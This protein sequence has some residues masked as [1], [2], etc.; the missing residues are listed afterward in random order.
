MPKPNQLFAN[1]VLADTFERIVREAEALGVDREPQLEAA[2][3]A[4]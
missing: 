4:F 3:N 1:P 2:R